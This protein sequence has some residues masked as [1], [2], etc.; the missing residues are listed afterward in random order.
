VRTGDLRKPMRLTADQERKL[1]QRD[2]QYGCGEGVA[3]QPLE[4]LDSCAGLV[5]GDGND[6][7]SSSLS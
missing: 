5:D 3:T 1:L 4:D 2:R 7:V 6:Q